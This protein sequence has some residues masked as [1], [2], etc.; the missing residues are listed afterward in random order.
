MSIKSVSRK[1][2]ACGLLSLSGTASL[3][4]LSLAAAAQVPNS[5]SPCY[6]RTSEGREYDLTA[7]CAGFENSQAVVLQTGDVQVTLRW[8]TADD[9]DL[10]VRD[11]SGDEVSYFQPEIASG[12]QLDVDANSDCS[13]RMAEPVENIFWPTDGGVPGNYVV[14]VDLFDHCGPEAPVSFTLTTLVQGQVQTQTGTVSASQPTVSFPFTFTDS[15]SS[16]S[17]SPNSSSNL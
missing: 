8:N 14:E 15:S 10:L 9:L 12:G 16:D 13:E 4:G 1:I 2:F 6:L 3:L 7:L 11:P 17:S 5:E